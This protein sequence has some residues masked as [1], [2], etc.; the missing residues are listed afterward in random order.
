MLKPPRQVASQLDIPKGTQVIVILSGGMDSAT[1]LAY[2]IHVWEKENVIALTFNYGQR[3]VKEMKAAADLANHYG[4]R[5]IVHRMDLRQIGGSALTDEISVPDSTQDVAEQGV[6]LTY[7]PMRNTIFLAIAAAYAEV[8]RCEYIYIG[9]NCI[10]SGGYPDTR[11]EFIRVMNALLM[12]GS[13]D[14]PTVV[15]P[16]ITSTKAN[17]VKEGEGLHVPWEKTWSCYEG[18]ET[19][20]GRCNACIQ[21]R[22][23]FIEARIVDPLDPEA[24]A[25]RGDEKKDWSVLK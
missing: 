9:V 11:P 14:K 19:P 25:V 12:A 3:H 16:Y 6:A 15:A 1:T 18:L 21:R 5:Q 8:L 23:G 22:K 24:T 20:C 13:R 10:D 17:I 7:V 4:V 2:A